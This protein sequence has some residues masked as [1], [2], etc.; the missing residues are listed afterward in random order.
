VYALHV[1]ALVA[2]PTI[3]AFVGI[4]MSQMAFGVLAWE[5]CQTWV[6]RMVFA[7]CWCV[8]VVHVDAMLKS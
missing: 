6:S 1:D 2:S 4:S 8:C 5:A 7:I 3:Q